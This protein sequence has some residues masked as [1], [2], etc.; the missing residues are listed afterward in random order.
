MQESLFRSFFLGGVECSTHRLQSGKR[1]DLISSTAHDRFYQQDYQRMQ[2]QGIYTIRS[3][4]RWHLIEQCPGKYDFSSVLPALW[5]AREMRMQVIW[6]LMHFGWPDDIDIFKPAFVDRF[7]QMVGAFVRI[8]ASE[9]DEIPF[10]CPINEI[11][12]LA[13]AG[14]EVAYMNPFSYGRGF[15]LKVQLARATIAAIEEIWQVV[16]HARIIH[17][18]PVI[19]V[20]AHPD[21][22]EDMFFAE[23][24]RLAQ[25]QA[26]DLLSGRLWPQIGGNPKYLDILGLN[27][28]EHN[29]RFCDGQTLD[30]FDPLYRPLSQILQ[31][32]Y[33][34]YQRPIFLAETG[35]EDEIRPEWL[36]Y[37]MSEVYDVMNANIPI[38]GICLYPIF[39]HPGW[40]DDRHCHNGLWDYADGHGAREIYQPLADELQRQQHEIVYTARPN[41][42]VY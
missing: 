15:E 14:G 34:R 23:S 29:Q 35:S 6:D 28:Y 26:W 7:S 8:L 33:E 30:R 13:W 4:I 22:P 31:E 12:F 41:R 24:D 42:G 5:T 25:F 21:R 38:E 27:Y 17:V 10:F 36:R 18:D 9:T 39:C 19:N 16:P 32:V 20:V 40:D 11:S 3:G 2:E 1:L 37:I